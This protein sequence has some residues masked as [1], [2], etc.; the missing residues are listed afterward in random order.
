MVQRAQAILTDDAAL[1]YDA[2]IELINTILA[3]T[4]GKV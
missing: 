4:E 3:I 1:Q 2:K